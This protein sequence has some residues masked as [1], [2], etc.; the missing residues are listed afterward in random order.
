MGAIVQFLKNIGNAIS[1]AFGFAIALVQ[2]L[3]WLVKSL[4]HFVAQLPNI[5]SWF[6]APLV[7]VLVAGFSLIVIYKILGRD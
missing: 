3:V 6:P 5:L 4:L 2:D 1:S 7:A